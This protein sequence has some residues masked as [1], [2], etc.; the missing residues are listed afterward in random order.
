MDV[1]AAANTLG[2]LGAVCWSIQLIPQIVVNARR[3]HATGLQPSMMMLWAWAGVPLG[4]YNIVEGFNVA[5]RVQPQ[6]LTALS[7]VTWVQC[8]HYQRKWTVTKSLLA[9]APIA[10]AMAGTQAALIVGLRA[11]RP[12]GVTWPATL[13]AALSAALLAAGVLRHYWD[14]YAHRT[15][16][17]VS[18]LFVAIDAA[19]DVFSLASVF[20]QRAPLDVLGIVIYGTEFALW[21]GVL[22]CGAWFNLRPWVREK[23]WLKGAR[24]G[25]GDDDDY[26][27]NET[28]AAEESRRNDETPWQ[29]GVSRTGAIAMHDLPSSTSV[30]TTASAATE[31]RARATAQRI[32]GDPMD[33]KGNPLA[34]DIVTHLNRSTLA[35]GC[36]SDLIRKAYGVCAEKARAAADET[37][38]GTTDLFPIFF[39][40]DDSKT[41]D[42]V[43]KLYRSI[44]KEC[45]G[46]VYAGTVSV[47]C[48]NAT[49][50]PNHLAKY[51]PE[52][53]YINYCP[54]F[55]EDIKNGWEGD[56]T[57]L[58][59]DGF[60]I[61]ELSHHLGGT[62]DF[63]FAYGLEGIATLSAEKRA[64]HADTF[65]HFATA[66]AHK[67]SSEKL[68]PLGSSWKGKPAPS[69]GDNSSII[70]QGT[71]TP[72]PEQTWSNKSPSETT[73]ADTA[74]TTATTAI[75]ST[76]TSPDGAQDTTLSGVQDGIEAQPTS[77]PATKHAR[78]NYISHEDRKGEMQEIPYA[79][80]IPLRRSII[81]LER[82]III[83]S[84][85]FEV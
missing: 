8:R 61:H 70:P 22:A 46:G 42:N 24:A 55:W 33:V 83:A 39:G 38:N 10:L 21:L 59:Y 69:Q 12:R 28:S 81:T 7:L 73:S 36:N 51:E 4:V 27:A 60:V 30:F 75:M 26:Y 82:D 65:A 17:G 67:C 3:H 52:P 15:V 47:S 9:A 44:A 66:V 19:G 20:F 77:E 5:L 43:S 54:G 84:P 31:M 50:C 25:R 78:S 68:G 45:D 74:P 63:N 49:Y 72:E 80:A 37:E 35:D 29:V 16:R 14:I 71:S 34:N 76:A 18:F 11:L 32:A 64:R 56:C 62:D 85:Q 57:K 2:I 6:I 23:G 41:R 40:N 1:P 48:S 58:G 13:M 79:E 53:N